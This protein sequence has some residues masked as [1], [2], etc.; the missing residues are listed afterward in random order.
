LV[1]GLA[2][3][4]LVAVT[5]SKAAGYKCRARVRREGHLCKDEKPASKQGLEEERRRENVK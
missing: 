5:L 1:E 2:Y 4:H 3:V